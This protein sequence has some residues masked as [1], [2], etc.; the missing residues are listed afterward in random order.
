MRLK[1]GKTPI[2]RES[3]YKVLANSKLCRNFARR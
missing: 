3:L 2:S 1:E